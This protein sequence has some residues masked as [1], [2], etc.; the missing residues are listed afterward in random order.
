MAGKKEAEA[1]C[2][3]MLDAMHQMG[4]WPTEFKGVHR[5]EREDRRAVKEV[6]EDCSRYV[7][8]SGNIKAGKSTLLNQLLFPGQAKSVLPTDPTP[9]TAKITFIESIPE[10]DPEH[11]E[12]EFYTAEEWRDV[13][14]GYAATKSNEKFLRNLQFSES[15]G[16][17]ADD[18]IG[19]KTVCFANFDKLAE[20]AACHDKAKVDLPGIC[21]GKY[22][23]YVRTVRVFCHSAWLARGTV[24][25]DTPGLA[26]P[27]PI[28]Q[29][30]TKRWIGRAVFV[31]YVH[32]IEDSPNLSRGQKEFIRD[33][34][35]D[36]DHGKFALVANFFDAHLDNELEDDEWDDGDILREANRI[37][38]VI[39]SEIPWCLASNI[40]P[41]SA[42]K[43][44]SDMRLDPSRFSEKIVPMLTQ[45][46]SI[47]EFFSRST[48]IIFQALSGRRDQL[49]RKKA[50]LEMFD[51]QMSDS[52]AENQKELAKLE[53]DEESWASD[54]S[55]LEGRKKEEIKGQMLS[56]NT[57]IK[58]VKGKIEDSIVTSLESYTKTGELAASIERV[59][60]RTL[61]DHLAPFHERA[62]RDMINYRNAAV[63][64]EFRRQLVEYYN[65]YL[66]KSAAP[67]QTYAVKK[68]QVEFTELEAEI[69]KGD[70]KSEWAALTD[71]VDSFWSF[72]RTNLAKAKSGVV[73]ILEAHIYGK[74]DSVLKSHY[75]KPYEDMLE[76]ALSQINSFRDMRGSLKDS[77]QEAIEKKRNDTEAKY[78]KVEVDNQIRQMDNDMRSVENFIQTWAQKRDLLFGQLA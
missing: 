14:S 5:T 31:V 37:A 66:G 67:L 22:V 19:H 7:A 20:F 59:V 4:V 41:L 3:E 18:W 40:F 61:D 11:F 42:K 8:V 24:I 6:I 56:V 10:S 76:Y 44:H 16:A 54:I 45:S 30:E 74:G 28:N 51:K 38:E 58:K 34:L 65:I 2:G 69:W 60:N 23:P 50:E 72:Y 13:K 33:Y 68:C 1:F 29:D 49:N 43:L 9:E 25:V 15:V 62:Y 32:S 71:E 73:R 53:Q 26:D 36:I 55:E 21:R 77:L 47:R 70:L 57:A 75:I 64:D 27:N 63:G 39:K 17:R 35:S 48:K 12:V 52:L 78:N 46:V